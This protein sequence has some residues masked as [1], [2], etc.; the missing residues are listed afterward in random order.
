M[1]TE[2]RISDL[3]TQRDAIAA[4]E[5]RS[6]AEAEQARL[7]RITA[8]EALGELL[9]SEHLTYSEIIALTALCNRWSWY[10]AEY[11]NSLIPR[12]VELHELINGELPGGPNSI[13]EADALKRGAQTVLK[14]IHGE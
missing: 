2:T 10:P 1:I 6:K 7:R 12:W 11:R 3:R 9:A 14:L 8:A 5:A 4:D 13:D